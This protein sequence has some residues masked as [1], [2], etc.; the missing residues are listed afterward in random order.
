MPARDNTT[1]HV[2]RLAFAAALGVL[3][4]GT[5]AAQGFPRPLGATCD[6]P[7]WAIAQR[8]AMFWF[9]TGHSHSVARGTFALQPGQPGFSAM[10]RNAARVHAVDE[11]AEHTAAHEARPTS[12]AAILD[13]RHAHGRAAAV[14]GEMIEAFGASPQTLTMMRGQMCQPALREGLLHSIA[15]GREF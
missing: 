1:G 14:A 15:E 6:L 9:S 10:V 11:D 2:W 12:Q 13:G 7:G 3:A 5:A 4:A 8:P